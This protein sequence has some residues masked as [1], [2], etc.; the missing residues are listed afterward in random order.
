MMFADLGENVEQLLRRIDYV[1]EIVATDDLTDVEESE[2]EELDELNE[3]EKESVV[4]Q[5]TKRM[6]IE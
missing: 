2:S 4:M 3:E 1:Q 5:R 6:R